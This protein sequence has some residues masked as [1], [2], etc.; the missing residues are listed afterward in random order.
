[1]VVSLL[2]LPKDIDASRFWTENSGSGP[3]LIIMHADADRAMG[4]IRADH[5]HTAVIHSRER[6]TKF[7]ADVPGNFEQAFH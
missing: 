1:M 7:D 5:I 3:H 2:G 6:L 4:N